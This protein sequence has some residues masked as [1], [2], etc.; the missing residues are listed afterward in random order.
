MKAPQ[1]KPPRVR[2]V[3]RLVVSNPRQNALLKSVNKSDAVD[4]RKLAELLRTG[5]LSAVYHGERSTTTLK[6][7]A[8]SS[9]ALTEDTTGVRSRLK[10]LSRGQ[11][12]RAVGKRPLGRRHRAAWLEQLA[13]AGLVR[14]AQRLYPQLAAL[15]ALRREARR[16][17]GVEG[18][19]Q[20]PAQL[21]RPVPF[22]GPIRTALLL[23]RVG[24]PHRF[25]PKRQFWAYCGLALE[26]VSSASPH[27][28]SLRRPDLFP[29]PLPQ[30]VSCISSQT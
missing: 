26:R 24:T 9:A 7:L 27:N 8:A 4:A 20:A 17:L 28:L 21:L 19:K 14:R 6:P 29:H 23:G 11:A 3:E 13:G 2:R 5:S 10:A 12:I 25:R 1:A 15:Q 16:D 22:L 30:R 18:Q